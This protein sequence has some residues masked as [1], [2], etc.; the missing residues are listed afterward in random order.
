MDLI[1]EIYFQSILVSVRFPHL[2]FSVA[3]LLYGSFT[4]LLVTNGYAPRA[5][6][7]G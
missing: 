2:Y 5:K 4:D 1:G 6:V 3:Q 7:L